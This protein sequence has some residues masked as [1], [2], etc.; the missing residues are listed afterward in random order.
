MHEQT[1]LL[2]HTFAPTVKW[3][4]VEF[5]TALKLHHHESLLT[6]EFDQLAAGAS[7]AA[8]KWNARYP[9]RSRYRFAG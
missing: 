4:L 1:L 2:T 6:P 3:E 8:W 7:Q 5:T 9:Y